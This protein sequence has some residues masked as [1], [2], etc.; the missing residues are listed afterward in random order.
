VEDYV[1]HHRFSYYPVVDEA[2][3]LVGLLSARAPRE[4]ASQLWLQTPVA[5][6]M[7]A[8]DQSLIL[9]PEADAMDALS[10]LRQREEHRAVIVQGRKPVGIVSLRDL[11]NFLALKIDLEPRRR[12]S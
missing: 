8:A 10:A 5:R 6:V 4:V 1:F 12:Y 7:K 2:G 9:D 3:D 11:L